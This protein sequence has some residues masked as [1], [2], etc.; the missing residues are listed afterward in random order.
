MPIWVWV[1]IAIAVIALLG[2][3][4]F[5]VWRRWWYGYSR[6]YLVRLVGKQES[7]AASRRTLQA[8]LRH[9]RDEPEEELL[10]FATDSDSVDR[11]ALVEEHQRCV[12]LEEELRVMPMPKLLI[13][14]ADALADVAY[15]LSVEAGR[16]TLDMD[17]DAVL[18]RLAEL[19]LD[20]VNER[21]DEA[22]ERMKT[23]LEYYDVD[24]M[25]VYGGGLYI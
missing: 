1:L 8:I 25:A 23:A 18:E 11:G 12:L 2:V 3:A 17:E 13:P 14:A 20:V 4:G 21:F 6:R 7:L 19:D 9:L 22:Q 24:D 16:I 5:F 15:A 10:R